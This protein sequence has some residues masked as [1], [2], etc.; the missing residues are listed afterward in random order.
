MAVSVRFLLLVI[1]VRAIAGLKDAFVHTVDSLIGENVYLPCNV[2]TNDGDEAVLILW[3]RDDK[4]TPIYSVDMRAGTSKAPKRWSDDVVFGERAFFGFENE[5]GKLSIEKVHANDSGVYRCRVDFLKA[6]TYN[7]RIML[8]VITPP[9]QVVIRDG[10][11]VERSTV[12]G[13]Y[14]EGDVVALKCQVLGGYP[15]PSITWYRD[16]AEIPSDTTYLSEGKVLQSEILLGPLGRS[17][18]NSRLVCRALNHPRASVVEAVVQIDMN[19]APLNIRL[20][21]AYQPLSA[22]RRYDL[23]CQSAGS[24]PPAVITWWQNGVRLE[25]TTETTSSDGNQTTSTLSI[26]LSKSDSGKFLSCKAYNH[27]IQSDPLEDGWKLDIQYIPEVFVRLGTS[28]NANALREGTDVYFDCFVVAHPQVFRIEWRHNDQP[29]LHNISQGVII[30][31]HSLVLQGVTKVTA[32]NYT[33]VGFN[34]EGEGISEPFNLNILYAPTCA[35]NQPKIY[36][37]AKQEDAHV[38][39]IVDANP[40]DVDFSW[41]FNNSAESIDV[42]TNHISRLGT[43][44]VLTY[45]PVTELDYGTLLCVATNKIG[46]QRTPCVF[47]IIAAGR[48]DQVHNCTLLNI[49]MTSLTATCSDAFNGGLPQLFILELHE[50]NSKE[51]KANI[52]SSVPRFTVSG[53]VPGN[54]YILSI[55]AYNSKGRSDPTIV[56]AATMRMP[57]KQLTFEQTHKPRAELLFSPMVSLTIGL[58]LAMIIATFAIV[59]ALRI[60][61]T[62][63]SKRRQK[64]VTNGND[65]RDVSPGPSDQSASK[66]V[67]ENDERNPDVVPE[68]IDFDDQRESARKTQHISTIDTTTCNPRRSILVNAPLGQSLDTADRAFCAAHSIG[69]CTLRFGRQVQN[70]RPIGTLPMNVTPHV[71][72]NA[73]AQC[74]LPRQ[75]YQNEWPRYASNVPEASHAGLN[76]TF[77]QISTPAEKCDSHLTRDTTEDY[78]SSSSSASNSSMVSA[79]NTFAQSRGRTIALHHMNQVQ[80]G[81]VCVEAASNVISSVEQT[82]SDDEATVQTPLMIKRDSSV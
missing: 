41:T 23:L 21:G 30:S 12:V 64:V 8:N 17:D 25:K 14:S 11:N 27:A 44:S 42:A 16:G 39:C 28:L 48:P 24:R 54:M 19:F 9:K 68:I 60:P 82:Q 6:Q 29:L 5:P 22:G 20:L 69:Y 55:F 73:I 80:S 78:A 2:T 62:A 58:A 15:T 50:A 74:T 45:T 46:R 51:I 77:H 61:C 38:K 18:L 57:E 65:S 33:C 7:T 66:D 1:F 40:F 52:T 72:S 76:S 43:T 34:A 47:H 49:S 71:Y 53:L 13:P 75:S 10:A 81:R 70:K 32:G 37:V 36:G 63:S 31:N 3:Y 79:P 35:Q 26:N 67:D 4:G 59:L 56:N